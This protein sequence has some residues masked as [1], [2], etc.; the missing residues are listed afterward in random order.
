LADLI[1]TENYVE[2]PFVIVK[3]GDTTFGSYSGEADKRILGSTLKVTYPNFMKGISVVKVNG[4]VN[5]YTVNMVYAITENDDPN[6]L[7]KV[8]SSIRD[9]REMTLT[10]GDWNS[11]SNIYK[12][13]TALVTSVKSQLDVRNSKITYTITGVSNALAL[14]SAVYDFPAREAKPSD[15][16]REI[17]YTPSYGLLNVFT[18]MTNKSA[19]NNAGLLASD[20]QKVTIEAKTGTNVVDYINYLTS[21]MM[22]SSSKGNI[23][24]SV[25]QMAI[26]DDSTNSMGGPYFQVKKIS[27][28]TNRSTADNA[29]EIDVGFPGSNQVMSFSVDNDESWSLLYDYQDKITQSSYSYKIDNKGELQ[30]TETPSIMR[31]RRHKNL[32]EKNK[33]WWTK[34][35]QF[36]ITATLTLKGLVRP[37]LLMDYIKVNVLFYG[38]KHIATG[39]YVITK[40]ED[41]INESGYR[42]T[43]TLL[44]VGGE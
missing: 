40:Q 32:T 29:W 33:T 42:T 1:S 21:Y 43:L 8:F 27:V 24:D 23:G 2:C 34:M 5:T 10:Y 16:I 37:T 14:S 15:V 6:M 25:Y 18:G 36:P 31:S 22:S 39:T 17:L 13:E 26:R 9:E 28:N 30:I 19:V 35:T 4:E 3:I 7:E 12:N 41:T 11:P 38:R 20:D 44:R